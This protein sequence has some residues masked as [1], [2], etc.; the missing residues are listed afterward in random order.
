MTR[1][2]LQYGRNSRLK[3]A[4]MISA[5]ALSPLLSG[6]GSVSYD[7][8]SLNSSGYTVT[9]TVS[10]NTFLGVDMEG[11]PPTSTGAGQAAYSRPTTM[12]SGGE[13]STFVL[14][15]GHNP[16]SSSQS[17]SS[18]SPSTVSPGAAHK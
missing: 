11:G 6:C 18:S 7:V 8:T 2:T 10:H 9:E 17:S 12:E 3:V 1:R 13:I 16:P 4:G 15:G 5:L 14:G